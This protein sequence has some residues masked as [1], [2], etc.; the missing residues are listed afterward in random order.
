MLLRYNDNLWDGME[1]VLGKMVSGVTF[2][3]LTEQKRLVYG[4][5]PNAKDASSQIFLTAT[6]RDGTWHPDDLR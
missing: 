3:S 2:F 1:S 4:I 6:S 5:F